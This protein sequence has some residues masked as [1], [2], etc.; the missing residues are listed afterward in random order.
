MHAATSRKWLV[1]HV[2]RGE[3]APVGAVGEHGVRSRRPS[4]V[5]TV[6]PSGRWRSSSS[7]CAILPEESFTP[8]IP[9]QL[10]PARAAVVVCWHEPLRSGSRN[11]KTARDRVMVAGLL[12]VRE[13]RRSSD[14]VPPL[15]SH[16]RRWTSLSPGPQPALAAGAL[17]VTGHVGG[18]MPARRRRC[19]RQAR[20][21][22][23]S[24]APH[25]ARRSRGRQRPRSR[26][27]E[28]WPFRIDKAMPLYRRCVG[29]RSVSAAGIGPL[30]NARSRRRLYHRRTAGFA[31]LNTFNGSIAASPAIPPP[32]VTSA[33]HHAAAGSEWRR[34]RVRNS[35]E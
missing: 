12:R 16:H 26:V 17:E 32:A 23:G 14:Q 33:H 8:A 7:D 2:R 27:C 11:G 19:H 1:I 30:L 24:S 15:A 10:A 34:T 9:R 18:S 5:S 31:P 35:Q 20:R 4:P 25:L 22:R 21:S 28:T 6:R 3:D 29:S 13:R